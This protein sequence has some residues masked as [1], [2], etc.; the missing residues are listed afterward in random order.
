MPISVCVC[1]V[2]LRQQ[3]DRHPN[4]AAARQR[5]RS[6]GQKKQNDEQSS[7]PTPRRSPSGSC[8]TV[9]PQLRH[10]AWP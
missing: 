8:A 3:I 2:G 10:C 5:D 6:S 1:G 4:V 9:E 7:E